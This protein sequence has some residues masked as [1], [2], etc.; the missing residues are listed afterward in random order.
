MNDRRERR[1]SSKAAT[2]T[3]RRLLKVV[4]FGGLAV[5]GLLRIRPYLKV[6]PRQT[7]LPLTSALPPLGEPSFQVHGHPFPH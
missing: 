4:S 3:V 2:P 5:W 7:K 1:L 6:L